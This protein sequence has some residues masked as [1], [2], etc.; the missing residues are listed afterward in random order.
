[1]GHDTGEEISTALREH[2]P[3]TGPELAALLDMHP[4]TVERRCRALQRAGRV[5]LVT[6]G[7]YALTDDGCVRSR[8]AAD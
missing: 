4:A 5:R 2:G 7:R 6:G 3:A 1:M 8:T